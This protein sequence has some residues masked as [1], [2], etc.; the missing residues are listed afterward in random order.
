MTETPD[1]WRDGAAH[2]AAETDPG[3]VILVLPEP[4]QQAVPPPGGASPD[5]DDAFGAFPWTGRTALP[6]VTDR[7]AAPC[8][9]I[10]PFDDAEQWA[11]QQDA[12]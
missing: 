1:G 2:C 8:C 3:L 11:P 4:A 5:D 6:P 12:P 10:A 9:A 7:T